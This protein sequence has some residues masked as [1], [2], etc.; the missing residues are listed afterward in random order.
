M[1]IPAIRAKIGTWT[2]YITT[3]TFQQ[4]N[5]S[6]SKI[7]D[8]LHKSESLRD[9]IQRSITNNYLSIKDY[10]INQPDLFF[11][12]LVLAAYDDYPNWIEIEVKYDGDETHQIGL[13]EFPS[14]HKIFPVD[15]QHRVEGI[16]AAL[17]EKPDL[18][19]EQVGAIF[20]GHKNNEKGMQRTRRLFTT[21]NRYAKP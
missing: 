18:K 9:L 6:V 13:L 4:I 8:E 7:D 19:L 16:K 15:G 20:I 12:S 11:N 14:Q 1:R 2:Y 21:L 5:D 17:R 10:L 3:L